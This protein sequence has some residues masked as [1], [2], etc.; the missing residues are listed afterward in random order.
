MAKRQSTKG[1]LPQRLLAKEH[2]GHEN[3][4]CELV[5]NREMNKGRFTVSC[6]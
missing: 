6:G 5:S 2:K 3:H 4:L 1:A